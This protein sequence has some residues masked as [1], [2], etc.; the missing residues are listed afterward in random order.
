M[1]AILDTGIDIGH[2][3]R[4]QKIAGGHNARAGEDPSDFQDFNG[5]GTHMAG[6]IAAAWNG[7]GII[8]M[9]TYPQLVAVRVLDDSGHGHLS[10][11]INGLEAAYPQ[12]IA[13]VATDTTNKLTDYNRFGPE[14]DLAAPGGAA[15]SEQI[16][17]TTLDGG[18][19]LGTGSSQAAAHISGRVAVA[20]QLAPWLSAQEVVDLLKGTA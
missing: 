3:E 20:L 14:V 15:Q 1:V 13:V 9:A 17:S 10:D 4:V 7:E 8:G 5:H 11:L 6:I 12:V 19:G 2:P 18:Y 16:L